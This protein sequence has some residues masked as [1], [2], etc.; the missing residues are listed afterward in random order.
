MKLMPGVSV[1]EAHDE[2]VSMSDIATRASVAHE[3]VRLWATGKRRSSIRSFPIPRQVVGNGSGGKTMNLYAWREVVCWIREV[4]GTDPDEGI[5][6][7]S[8][9]EYAH[10]NA[11]LAAIREELTGAH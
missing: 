1:A 7:L 10:L 4:L 8:D 9:T 11:E 2:L 3:A 5:D 6:Y